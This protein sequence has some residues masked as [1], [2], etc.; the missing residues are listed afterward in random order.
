MARYRHWLSGQ[1][2]LV[3]RCGRTG[4]QPVDRD[5]LAATHDDRVA[6]GDLFDGHISNRGTSRRWA[7]LGRAVDQGP[8]VP[9]GP[10]DSKILQHVA[11]GVHDGN[12]DRRQILAKGKGR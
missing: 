2:R 8:Q 3:D 10:R 9:L 5:D 7:A 6:D 1:H 11:A 4:D 12:D